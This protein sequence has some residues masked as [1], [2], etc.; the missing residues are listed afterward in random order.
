MGVVVYDDVALAVAHP[1][2]IT[3]L[4]FPLSLF[5]EPFVVLLL[6]RGPNRWSQ[7]VL[8]DVYELAWTATVVII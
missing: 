6:R 3:S 8:T 1:H 5:V 2:E 7:D 4:C